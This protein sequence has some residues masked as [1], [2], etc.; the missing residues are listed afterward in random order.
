MNNFSKISVI[1]LVLSIFLNSCSNNNDKPYAVNGILNITDY[2]LNQDIINLDG[3]WEFYWNQLISPEDFR[4]NKVGENIY[5]NV[6]GIWND[7]KEE[8][9]S[10]S[11][12]GFATYRLQIY[13]QSSD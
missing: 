12:Q 5:S 1:L 13:N 3:K 9:S 6:P 2:H 8:N 11:G 4:R 10:I 7:L